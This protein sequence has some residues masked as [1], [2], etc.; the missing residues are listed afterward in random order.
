MCL[1]DK[2]ITI[3][4]IE[5]KLYVKPKAHEG[6]GSVFSFLNYCLFLSYCYCLLAFLWG[7]TTRVREQMW[8]D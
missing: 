5:I 7:D 1:L 2:D 8:R 3:K 4:T 6:M